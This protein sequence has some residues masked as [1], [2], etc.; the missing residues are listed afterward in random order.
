M[1]ENKKY[2][3][4]L[5]KKKSSR[6]DIKS[7]DSCSSCSVFL[8]FL[9]Y[10][11]IS[12]EKKLLLIDKYRKINKIK[13]FFYIYKINFL[14]KAF[15]TCLSNLYIMLTFKFFFFFFELKPFYYSYY[16]KLEKLHF[17]SRKNHQDKKF[18]IAFNLSD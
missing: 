13:A 9:I 1:C 18:V 10:S 6:Q 5:I 8:S 7:F 11:N 16:T 14:Y 4:T 2:Y 3:R 17:N 15:M 12:I